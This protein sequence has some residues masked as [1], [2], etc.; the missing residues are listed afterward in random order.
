MQHPSAGAAAAAPPSPGSL[1]TDW[2][3]PLHLSCLLATTSPDRVGQQQRSGETA[4]RQKLGQL[5]LLCSTTDEQFELTHRQPHHTD[6]LMTGQQTAPSRRTCSCSP[7]ASRYSS[8]RGR[9]PL[10]LRE[11]C[12]GQVHLTTRPRVGVWRDPEPG[13]LA[14]ERPARQSSLRN[15]SACSNSM[16]A[17]TAAESKVTNFG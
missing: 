3:R 16:C 12:S 14:K 10:K 13:V 7:V 8:R 5:L 1:G 9:R 17:D 2:P 11:N 15:T 4:T 6:P